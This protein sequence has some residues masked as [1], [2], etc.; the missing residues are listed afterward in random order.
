V[1]ELHVRTVPVDVSLND[2]RLLTRIVPF[3]VSTPVAD[4]RSDGTFDAYIEG[5]RRGVFGRQATST[6][7]GV[8]RRVMLKHEHD[9]GL[10][11]LGPL[12]SLEERD[13]GAYAEFMV[14]PS[15]RADVMAL[16]E[17]GIREMSVEFLERKDGTAEEDGVRWRTSAHL[18]GAAL[19][20]KGAY[21]ALGAEV[22]AM[23][24]IDELIAEQAA[25]QEAER[26]RAEAE[27][28][29]ARERAEAEEVARVA[30]EAEAVA[31]EERR[32]AVVE[33]EAF[34][35]DAQARQAELAERY[36]A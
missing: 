10:G 22:L 28:V 5:F 27:E 23:R 29:A 6:E 1:T 12:V 18:I 16:H 4:V 32:R 14:L 7:P 20:A 8:L 26:Q 3:D 15:Y 25:T 33:M 31:A 13:D 2:G 17:V 21:G 36:S 35:A 11:Y 30:A 24:S 34:L 19:V 9:G